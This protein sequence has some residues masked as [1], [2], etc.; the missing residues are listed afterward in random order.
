MTTNPNNDGLT[1]S[2][3]FQRFRNIL[4]TAER[5]S[6]V[7]Q[8]VIRGICN[9]LNRAAQNTNQEQSPHTLQEIARHLQPLLKE[10]TRDDL[11][12]IVETITIVYLQQRINLQGGDDEFKYNGSC[13][14]IWVRGN[15]LLTTIEEIILQWLGN[16]KYPIA[17]QVAM[18]AKVEFA[19]A[20]D[21]AEEKR[22]Q[23]IREELGISSDTDLDKPIT[24]KLRSFL[25]DK[26]VGILA[27]IG[28][29]S[30]LP[31]VGKILPEAFYQD[32]SNHEAVDF[33]LRKWKDDENSNTEIATGL[34]LS[35]TSHRLGLGLTLAKNPLLWIVPSSLAM[36]AFGYGA[37]SAKAGVENIIKIVTASPPPPPCLPPQEPN[38]GIPVL[39]NGN[40]KDMDYP[41]N[42]DMGQL[43][44]EFSSGATVDDRVWIHHQGKNQGEIG[45]DCKNN[46]TYGGEVIGKVEGEGAKPLVVTF[47]DKSNPDAATALLRNIKYANG[48]QTPIEDRRELKFKVSDGQEN[49]QS[50]S[51][52]KLIHLTTEN[53]TPVVT[54]PGEQTVKE[55]STLIIPGI[56][57]SD[58]DSQ[59]IEVN[60][61]VNNGILTVKKPADQKL[62]NKN[63]QA[64][65]PHVAKEL[66]NQ[67]SQADKPDASQEVKDKNNQPKRPDVNKAVK[68]QNNAG[69]KVIL[70]GTPAAINALLADSNAITYKPQEKFDGEDSLTVTVKDNGKTIPGVNAKNLVYPENAAQ[71]KTA[72]SKNIKITV[73]PLKP[74]AVINVPG[75][76]EVKE[77]S[78]V[79]IGGISISDTKNR[80][81]ITVTLAANKGVLTVKDNVGNG[82]TD[83]EISGK[84]KPT[85]TLKGTLAQINATL[86]D[87]NAIIYRQNPAISR[88]SDNRFSEDRLTITVENGSRK[89]SEKSINITINHLNQA[90]TIE[91]S[92]ESTP[93]RNEN[94]VSNDIRLTKEQAVDVVRKYLV[95]AKPQIFAHPYN[96]EIVAQYASGKYFEAVI[97][98]IDELKQKNQHYQFISQQRE[99]L[100]YF[101]T[102]GNEAE[103]DVRIIEKMHLYENGSFKEDK[104]YAVSY[105]F[106]LINDNGIWKIADRKSLK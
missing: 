37:Y 56:K 75:N 64:A 91:E 20:L 67:S 21:Q 3:I 62:T 22:I 41:S 12:K 5:H 80:D 79:S 26:I 40:I 47:N 105:R 7:R 15:R 85:I 74:P 10:F 49:G 71:A 101:S 24:G 2:E 58:P 72:E 30:Y 17:Q 66:K 1:I 77:K 95:E 34:Q 46:V 69:K 6:T 54:V 103:I 39:P 11:D 99:P 88:P 19:N 97:E 87:A 68:I 93:L 33:V 57:I 43:T 76:K 92:V 78:N 13:Y 86:A 61:I 81:K 65:K 94:T 55:N 83:K 53:Q 90:P 32:K 60:L 27:T 8:A 84:D 73:T 18:Q 98:S 23:E 44:V 96:K 104:S 63:N 89:S 70:I 52:T 31:V 29:T 25:P 14:Q 100:E 51:L 36:G 35:T 42:F 38:N 102:N 48:S 82:L 28:K 59:E 4:N 9:L 45:I 16:K 50:K 106:M